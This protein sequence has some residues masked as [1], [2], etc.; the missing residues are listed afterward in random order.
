MGEGRKNKGPERVF[1]VMSRMP[2]SSSGPACQSCC[3]GFVQHCCAITSGGAA[4]GS[5]CHSFIAIVCRKNP[6]DPTIGLCFRSV[7]NWFAA[8]FS[9]LFLSP[10]FSLATGHQSLPLS[11]CF[12][13]HFSVFSIGITGPH[14]VT[15]HNKCMTAAAAS[16]MPNGLIDIKGVGW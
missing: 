16:I 11:F 12:L 3:F 8:V 9:L 14:H 10:P 13:N 7:H 2:G 6:L 5:T 4:A 15:C 1:D